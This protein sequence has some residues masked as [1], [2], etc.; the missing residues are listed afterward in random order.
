MSILDRVAA[1]TRDYG[2]RGIQRYLAPNTDNYKYHVTET[3]PGPFRPRRKRSRDGEC[4]RVRQSRCRADCRADRKTLP[5]PMRPPLGARN[6]RLLAHRRTRA[7]VLPAATNPPRRV[8]GLRGKGGSIS[9]GS[10]LEGP[11]SARS[12]SISGASNPVKETSKPSAGRRSI[13]SPGSIARIS[14][15]QPVCSASLLTAIT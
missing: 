3:A 5:M 15:S 13:S 11:I 14:R 8:V 1:P 6:R 4:A 7:G 10:G 9:P 2:P 12:R